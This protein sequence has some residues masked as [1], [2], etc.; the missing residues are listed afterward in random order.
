MCSVL[1]RGGPVLEHTQGWAGP[2]Q[3]PACVHNN[4][5]V[6]TDGRTSRTMSKKISI[7]YSLTDGCSKVQPRRAA[8]QLNMINGILKNSLISPKEM[9]IFS[10]VF[11]AS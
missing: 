8:D 1:I 3:L 9:R 2:G 6:M 10:P 5:A 7:K 4:D 11:V